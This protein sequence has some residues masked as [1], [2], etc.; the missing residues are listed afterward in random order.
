MEYE[1]V[2]GLE[3][4]VQLKTRSKMFG[5]SSAEYQT[6]EPN[7]LVDEVSMA[8]PGTLPVVNQT[9]VEY[10]MMIGM[11]INCN[12]ARITKFDR[13]NY[14][15]PDLMKGYQITQFDEP[16]CYDGFVDLPLD[17]PVR[18]RINRVHMEEDV[19]RLVHVEGPQGGT[20]HS[21]ID[22]NRAGTPLMEIV[23]EPDMHTSEQVESYINSLQHI[24]RYLGVGTANMEEGS[25]RCDANISV[26]PQGSTE[27]TT[28]VEVKNMNR[29]RAVVRAVEY[30]IERQIAAYESGE[31]IIQETR[32][33][34]DGKGVTKSQRSKE[35]ANDYRYF[36]EP[37][38]PPLIISEDWIEGTQAKMPELPI[39]RK[40]RF[41]SEWGLTEYDA[42]LLTFI[43][44]T[45]DYFEA[46]CDVV[47]PESPDTKQAFA[48]AAANWLN[49]EMARKMND[50]ELINMFDTNIAPES[51]STLVE[52]FRK[53]ELNNNSA[54]Q[55]FELMYNEGSD[56]E[57][58]IKDLGLGVVS[59][60][61]A[62]GPIVDEVIANN[63]KAVDDYLGGKE[64]ALKSLMGQVMKATRGQADPMQA[65]EM[66]KEKLTSH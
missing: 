8:L 39:A 15:Y 44:S 29:I 11:A 9:A 43:R 16:I 30:E 64:V 42:D 54:K 21:L 31:R 19:A 47:K 63:K 45:A 36:P 28:K 65:T 49:G 3:T 50:D 51:L 55:V 25:F 52:K 59:G 56:P 58:V 4:H 20:V 35:E 7:T 37:D 6:A 2:I 27:L 26:R 41:M 62:L 34:D 32:G 60:A 22:I 14:T 17:N 1:A 24:I 12:I 46:V 38:I 5:T 48:K 10:A 33:W 13:K 40:N 61:D 23:T 66:I 57:K 53:R 18:V